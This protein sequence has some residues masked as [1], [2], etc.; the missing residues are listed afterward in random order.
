[1]GEVVEDAADHG[2]LWIELAV[3]PGPFEGRLGTA[4]DTIEM[5]LAFGFS[6]AL[7]SGIGF[8]LMVSANRHEGPQAASL[9]ARQVVSFVD[10]GVVSFGLDGDESA[11]PPAPRPAARHTSGPG[12][13]W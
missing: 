7:Q 13:G 10:E 8:G 4:E 12:R 6:A 3:W 9:L 1:L 11:L 2:A 5:L